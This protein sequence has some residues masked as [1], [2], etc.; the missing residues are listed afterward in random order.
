MFGGVAFNNFGG[1]WSRGPP[2]M[3]CRLAQPAS[4]KKAGKIRAKNGHFLFNIV[5]KR[6]RRFLCF[7]E[8]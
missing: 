4:S 8:A 2:V 1:S 5:F 3:A 7:Y 6:Y